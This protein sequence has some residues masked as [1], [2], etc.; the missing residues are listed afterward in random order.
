M[1]I[2]WERDWYRVFHGLAF[3]IPPWNGVDNVWEPPRPPRLSE[4]NAAQVKAWNEEMKWICWTKKKTRYQIRGIAAEPQ[5]WEEL[6]LARSANQIRKACDASTFWLNSRACPYPYVVDLRANASTFLRGKRY[7]CPNSNRPSSKKKLV[8]H[9]A[10]VMAGI[11]VGISPA[12]AIDRMRLLPRR[13]TEPFECAEFY[14]SS[15]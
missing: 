10:R 2:A 14:C 9:F 15:L 6:K 11:T 3:G 7:R 8:A 5:V 12:R 1:L 4:F 13:K